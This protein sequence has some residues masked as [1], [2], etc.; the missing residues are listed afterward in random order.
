MIFH[1]F[2]A[3]EA[4]TIASELADQ[5]APRSATGSPDRVAPAKDGAASLQNLLR[6]A[7]KDGRLAGLN[8]YK[9]ARFANSLK[10][11]LLEN[12][13][14]PRTAD[15]VTHSLLV[16]LS[17]VGASVTE[18]PVVAEDARSAMEKIPDL[19]RRGNKALAGGA[20]EDARELYQAVVD[21]DPANPVALNNLGAALCKIGNY[22]EAE[23]R[24]R[25]ALSL[26]AAYAEA[27]CNLGNVLRWMG[28]SEESEIWLRRA[29]KANP[30]YD[31]A[32]ISL[33]LTLTLLG[34]IRDAKARFEKVLKTA[35]RD[36]DALFGMALIAKVEGRFAD[37]EALFRRV[38]EQKPR[39]AAAWA[40]LVTL[41]KMTPADSDWL[42]ATSELVAGGVTPLEEADLRFA[43][44]KYHDDLNEFDHAFRSFDAA[45]VILKEIAIKYDR[46]G[47]D[48]FVDDM[49]RL[50][51]KEAIAAI[52]DG[53]SE[54]SKPV[55]VVGMPRSGTSLTE[56][57]LASHPSVFGA[58]EMDFWNAF[59]RLHQAEVRE[60]LLDPAK[61]KELA[62]D[63]LRLLESR[64][65]AVRIIDKT[66]INSDYI[67]MIYSA[68]P[69]TRFIYL[70]RD[71][72]DTCLSCYFQQFGAAL[73]FTM[74]LSDLA[75]YYKAHR[76]LFKHWQSV[77]PADRILVVPYEQLVQQPEQWVR[78]MLDFLGLDW[79][80]RCLS[81]HDTQRI[82][83]T[84]STWQIR[85]KIYTRSV[86]R[87][88]SY[89]KHIGPLK[90]LKS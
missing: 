43:I 45:N 74:D 18:E 39:M 67:G 13:M 89:K 83:T 34:R 25:Q 16:Q 75:H 42:R 54:S 9:K 10:W 6:R 70:Q 84:A 27:N 8:F 63:Y 31:D 57:I 72:I 36:A 49:L 28:N 55:F 38:L 59:T 17:K 47:R 87:W 29:L 35:P 21:L 60:Q 69:N 66:T 53:G 12:G 46:K 37:A 22:I 71:P 3:S 73:N 32:R 90:A 86:G 80:D 14:E 56:Q 33:G 7:A 81:F 77:L 40:A 64:G 4:E 61:R 24:F 79:Y 82:V 23:Q 2:N 62:N 19:L 44:G 78:R 5:F 41:R 68:L 52:G 76:K 30:N 1:W 48:G 15:H 50:Y 88:Q 51:T 85:Q 58:G 11:R 20:F 65:D 26:D